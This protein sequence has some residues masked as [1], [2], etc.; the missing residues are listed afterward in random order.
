[1]NIWIFNHYATGLNSSGGTR[2]FDL[3]KQLVRK[4][5][6]VTIF[7]SSFSHYTLKDEHLANSKTDYKE[8][9]YEGVRFLWIKT[10]SYKSNNHKRVLNMLSYTTKAMKVAKNK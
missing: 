2:H 3:A 1:M 5:H 7:A 9:V 8:E 4:G 6:S 10:V